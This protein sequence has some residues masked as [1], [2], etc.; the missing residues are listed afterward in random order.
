MVG[1]QRRVKPI[2]YP[3]H[4]S[5]AE[6]S[7]EAAREACYQQN[8]QWPFFTD[9]TVQRKNDFLQMSEPQQHFKHNFFAIII[10]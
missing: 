1:T 2:G 5:V 3:T 8:T 10:Q 7:Y 6:C 4:V 9:T